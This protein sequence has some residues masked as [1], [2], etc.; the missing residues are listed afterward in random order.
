[1]T[2]IEVGK[3]YKFEIREVYQNYLYVNIIDMLL[4]YISLNDVEDHHIFNKGMH[5]IVK[6]YHIESHWNHLMIT[7]SIS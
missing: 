6:I 2:K 4:V 7:G 1:M 3:T 5:I